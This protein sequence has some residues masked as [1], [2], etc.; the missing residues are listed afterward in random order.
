MSELPDP[1]RFP[2]LISL[3]LARIQPSR[4]RIPGRDKHPSV[5]LSL[6]IRFGTETFCLPFGYVR[7]S[8]KRG[9]LKLGIENGKIPLNH[10]GLVSPLE[11]KFELEKKQLRGH[12]SGATVGG[13]LGLSFKSSTQDSFSVKSQLSNVRIR[14]KGTER[15]PTWEFEANSCEFPHLEGQLTDCSLGRAYVECRDWSVQ[16]EFIAY[17]QRDLYLEAGGL[18]PK[19][20]SRNKL[21]ILERMFF[22][23]FIKPR[24]QP[25]LS[26]VEV[27]S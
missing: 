3:R 18:W 9:E 5:D 25:Y 22:Y 20:L 23:R 14:T 17:V 12:E 6:T 21:A 19:E 4:M 26:R 2:S 24:F 11:T 27:K 1:D 10:M 15:S 8:L 16:A 7:V 13:G